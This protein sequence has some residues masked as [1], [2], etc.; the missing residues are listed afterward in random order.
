M[1]SSPAGCTTP[2]LRLGRWRYLQVFAILAF[3]KNRPKFSLTGKDRQNA[4]NGRRPSPLGQN[5]RLVA[6]STLCLVSIQHA[7]KE[8]GNALALDAVLSLQRLFNVLVADGCGLWIRSLV[9][10]NI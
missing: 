6:I 8:V 10:T 7:D 3:A 9:P 1:G 2:F 4:A 5:N